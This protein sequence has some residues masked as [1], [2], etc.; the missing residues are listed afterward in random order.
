VAALVGLALSAAVGCA[1]T[2]LRTHAVAIRGFQYLPDTVTAQVGDTVA[3]INEDLVPHTAT[4]DGKPL[5]SGSIGHKQS[6]R[7]VA[8]RKGTYEYVCAFHP[9]MKGTLVVR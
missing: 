7:Y 4:A 1:M 3:W 6:W 5:D 8:T 2:K 9:T